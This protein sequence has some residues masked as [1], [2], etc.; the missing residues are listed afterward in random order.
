MGVDDQIVMLD[1]SNVEHF[2]KKDTVEVKELLV[3]FPLFAFITRDWLGMYSLSFADR[4][5]QMFILR[6]QK[7]TDRANKTKSFK[8]IDAAINNAK[9]LGIKSITVIFKSTEFNL[10]K[11]SLITQ[12]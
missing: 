9:K 12:A 6:T 1:F 11:G 8:N 4:S 2:E 3:T 10:I 5:G 7:R